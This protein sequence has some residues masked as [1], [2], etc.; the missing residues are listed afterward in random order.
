MENISKINLPKTYFIYLMLTPCTIVCT[1]SK[2]QVNNLVWENSRSNIIQN[3]HNSKRSTDLGL[4]NTILS[5]SKYVFTF[6]GSF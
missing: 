1:Y 6:L 3:I 4:T 2:V 5:I